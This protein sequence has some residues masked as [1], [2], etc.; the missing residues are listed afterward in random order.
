MKITKKR[1]VELGLLLCKEDCRDCMICYEK[2]EILYCDELSEDVSIDVAIE[3]GLECP[4]LDQDRLREV[5]TEEEYYA[6]RH[7]G[8]EIEE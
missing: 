1:A 5:M 6:Y 3:R 8:L 7:N 4:E 2:D